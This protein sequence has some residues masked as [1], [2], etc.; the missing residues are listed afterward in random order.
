[1][2]DPKLSISDS[3]PG[4]NMTSISGMPPVRAMDFR[5]IRED[6]EE[7]G[8]LV[9]DPGYTNTASCTS[10]ITFIDGRKGILRYRGYPIEQ[11]AEHCAYT[12]VAHLLLHGELPTQH[13]LDAWN[14]EIMENSMLHENIKKFMDGFLY[15]A[16]PMGMMVSTVAALSTFYPDAKD[17]ASKSN[18]YAQQVRLIGKMPTIA[19][20]AYRKSQ[21]YPYAYPDWDLATAKT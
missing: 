10:R 21:G 7:F 9:Y 14:T 2:G 19:A 16:H 17:I 12:E 15:D 4:K 6:P 5:A 13:E 8:M 3:A 18:R 11:L 20:Y 1:M